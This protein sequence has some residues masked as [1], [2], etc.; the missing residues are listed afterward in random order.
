VKVH[1]ATLAGGH[2]NADR[3]FVT[4]DAVIV[5]DGASAHEPVD[6]DPATYAQLLGATIAEQLD[7]SPVADLSAVVA[8]GI[9]DTAR[10]LRLTVGGSTTPSS[11]ISILRTR[12][13]IADLYVLGDSPIYYGTD[14]EAHRLADERLSAIAITERDRYVSRLAAGHGYDHWHQQALA[15]LQREQ[16]R[17]RNAPGGYWIAEADPAAAEHAL[18]ASLDPTSITW[19]VLATD[20]AADLINHADRPWAEVAQY[21]DSQ[22]TELL[23]EVH[24]WEAT[25]DQRGRTLPRAKQHDDKTVAAMPSAF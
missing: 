14:A 2:I 9:R 4:D 18:I 6:V 17:H 11:T 21:D 22:L 8:T 13:D 16:S 23:L 5:L 10:T 19:A 7:H 3:V 20:G 15:A 1:T 25:V 24:Q 12:D